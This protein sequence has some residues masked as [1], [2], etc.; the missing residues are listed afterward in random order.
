MAPTK[1]KAPKPRKAAKAAKAAKPGSK[2]TLLPVMRPAQNMR[3]IIK[4][5]IMLEDHLFQSCK[6]CGDC[7]NKHFLTIEALAEECGTLCDAANPAASREAQAVASEVRVLH[8]AWAQ[9][10]KGDGICTRV[11]GQLRQL[12]KRLMRTYAVLPLTTL[13]AAETKAVQGLLRR[14]R[15]R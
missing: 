8:H 10:P 3:E 6:R 7:V 15:R 2:R 9:D 4:Q 12:R 1:P 11:A 14:R 13:P 5:V